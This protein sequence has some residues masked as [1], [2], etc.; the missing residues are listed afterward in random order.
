MC[1]RRSSAW[2]PCG[3]DGRTWLAAS[4]AAT[5]PRTFP[6]F[7]NPTRRQASSDFACESSAAASQGVEIPLISCIPIKSCPSESTLQ[8]GRRTIFLTNRPCGRPPEGPLSGISVLRPRLGPSARR[9]GVIQQRVARFKPGD[10]VVDIETN[11]ESP[12]FASC[13]KR[14]PGRSVVPLGAAI[15]A[16]SDPVRRRV[17]AGAFSN[18]TRC[19]MT[20]FM[21]R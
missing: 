8:F 13:A 1:S 9:R 12:S 2:L 10:Q 16:T 4:L 19:H 18:E 7:S 5:R 11:H 20:S 6:N 21:T 17:A 3:G 14:R 15:P